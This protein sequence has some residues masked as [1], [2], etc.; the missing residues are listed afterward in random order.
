MFESGSAFLNVGPTAFSSS[1]SLSISVPCS[2]P[3]LFVQFGFEEDNPE[4]SDEDC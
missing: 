1:D 2:D 4:S 3:R